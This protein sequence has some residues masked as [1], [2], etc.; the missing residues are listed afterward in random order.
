MR[1]Q[2]HLETVHGF[3]SH[4]NIVS[5]DCPEALSLA[6]KKDES[7]VGLSSPPMSD[8]CINA[9]FNVSQTAADAIE[10]YF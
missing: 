9:F 8:E 5:G 6:N 1:F 10:L 4:L 3:V 2:A 7:L